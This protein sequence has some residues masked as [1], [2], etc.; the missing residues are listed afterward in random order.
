MGLMIQ[1]VAQSFCPEFSFSMDL[2]LLCCKD[3]SLIENIEM[4]Y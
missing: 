3:K 4:K 1:H 2:G